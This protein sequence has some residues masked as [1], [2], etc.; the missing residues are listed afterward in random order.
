MKEIQKLEQTLGY[1]FANRSLLL[2]ALTHSSFVNESRETGVS[3]N[4]R[5]EFLGD[6]VLGMI[7]AEHLFDTFSHTPEGELSKLRASVVCEDSLAR[8][9]RRM[10]LGNYLRMGRGEEKNGGRERDSILADA[11]EAVIA[12][13]YLDG[14]MDSIRPLVV[15]WLS[16]AA[17][18]SAHQ[19][20]MEQD[21]KTRLQE[22][23]QQSNHI[24]SYHLVG[25]SGPDHNKLFQTQVLLDGK[26]IAAGEGQSKKK[27]EQSAAK[28][29]LDILNS[30]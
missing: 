6:S 24:V 1:T 19:G 26:V 25:E 11:M 18:H 23:A 4:E 10:N 28:A 8:L 5:L 22:Y 16:D 3:S 9:A 17:A 27:S 13:I 7:M 15:G 12:A 21:Y 2:H 20:G 14:G 29:A 30:K